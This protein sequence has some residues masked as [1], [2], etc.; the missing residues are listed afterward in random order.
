MSA[1]I[2]DSRTISA[3]YAPRWPYSADINL[4]D[5]F[6]WIFPTIDARVFS[7]QRTFVNC[8][9]RA[10]L[11]ESL[12]TQMGLPQPETLNSDLSYW[13]YK[14]PLISTCF[15]SNDVRFFIT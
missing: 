7:P 6:E 3:G 15:S 11:E 14:S 13:K 5:F 4:P 8:S 12:F 10:G 9:A 2:T 1:L